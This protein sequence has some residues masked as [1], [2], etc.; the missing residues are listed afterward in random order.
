MS[1]KYGWPIDWVLVNI[2]NVNGIDDRLRMGLCWDSQDW[3]STFNM[4]IDQKPI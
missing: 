3:F 4:S 1:S 2:E